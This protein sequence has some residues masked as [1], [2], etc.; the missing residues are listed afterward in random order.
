M[1]IYIKWAT[2]FVLS[3]YY[4]GMGDVFIAQSYKVKQA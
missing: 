2:M 4:D 3:S 1:L